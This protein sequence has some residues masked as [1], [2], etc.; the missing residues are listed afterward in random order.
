[1]SRM[2]RCVAG[3]VFGSYPMYLMLTLLVWAAV[4]ASVTRHQTGLR[5]VVASIVVTVVLL[6]KFLG[7]V[8]TEL[9]KCPDFCPNFIMETGIHDDIVLPYIRP[10]I[11]EL[12]PWIGGL[13]CVTLV[14]WV[15]IRK[16][17]AL[18]ANAMPPA[19]PLPPP[20]P[21]ATRLPPPPPKTRQP[22]MGY[23]AGAT[24]LSTGWGGMYTFG[25]G[26]H[27]RFIDNRTMY[28]PAAEEEDPNEQESADFID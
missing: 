25:S 12:N 24:P 10:F 11:R 3:N 21:P 14:W 5:Y 16:P 19:T 23:D 9:S 28:A 26:S 20:P 6:E 1:M 2:D 22:T 13:E 18:V 15:L 27:N 8:D 17:T 7:L 4:F